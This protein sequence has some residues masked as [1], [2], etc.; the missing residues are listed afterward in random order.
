MVI[1][2]TKSRS[3]APALEHHSE[4]PWPGIGSLDLELSRLAF[5]VRRTE[6]TPLERIADVLSQLAGLQA[7]L[8]ASQAKLVSRMIGSRTNGKLEKDDIP[9]RWLTSDEAA[10]FLKVDRKWLYRL[11]CSIR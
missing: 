8:V 9:E 10:E 1:P 5:I 4:V 6:E 3:D 11:Y 7:I 2:L